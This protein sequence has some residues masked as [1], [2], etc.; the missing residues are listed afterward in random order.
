MASTST[1]V[2][3]DKHGW[4]AR[5]QKVDI[6]CPGDTIINA[7]VAS[8]NTADTKRRALAWMS[9]GQNHH[10]EMDDFRAKPCSLFPGNVCTRHKINGPRSHYL[11]VHTYG[12]QADLVF[13]V[14]LFWLL[15]YAIS[16]ISNIKHCTNPPP[17][18]A[19]P[20]APAGEAMLGAGAMEAELALTP[21]AEAAGAA[22]P[23]PPPPLAA[24]AADAAATA[25]ATPS[26]A[27]SAGLD[28]GTVCCALC[29]CAAAAKCCWLCMAC[30]RA[31]AATVPVTGAAA[32]AALEVCAGVVC[33]AK[34]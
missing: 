12:E 23:P 24:A 34:S 32:A 8:N 26:R 16:T 13:G 18:K 1:S 6:C 21:A 4:R 2:R 22:P 20:G 30:D 17:G 11:V 33:R 19:A 25:A 15:G 27:G 9:L 29:C 28:A 31:A 14:P 10:A 3:R 5:G 7:R